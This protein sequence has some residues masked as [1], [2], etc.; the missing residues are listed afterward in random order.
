MESCLESNKEKN[1]GNKKQIESDE[2]ESSKSSHESVEE[3]HH[4]NITFNKLELDKKEN[5]MFL[6]K[7]VI[8][9]FEDDEAIRVLGMKRDKN[10]FFCRMQWKRRKEGIEPGSSY[11]PLEVAKKKCIKLLIDFYETKLHFK[12]KL[13]RQNIF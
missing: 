12:K 5:E 1:K 3:N 2:E 9:N 11:Y 8:G 10:K 6:Q 7:V 4:C 13:R